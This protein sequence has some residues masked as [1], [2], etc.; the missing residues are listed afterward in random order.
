M[1][2]LVIAAV[3]WHPGE[4]AGFWGA[5][6]GRILDARF[7]MR[8]PLPPPDDVAVLLID[9]T[10]IAQIGH[11]P[12]PRSVLAAAIDKLR[13]S[14]ASAV[15]VDLLLADPSPDDDALRVTLG[16][17]GPVVLATA[18][19][20]PPST[21]DVLA[22]AITRSG[23]EVA[24]SA[25]PNAL[26]Q[27]LGPLP[28]FAATSMIGHANLALGSEGEL[29]SLPAALPFVG[30]DGGVWVPG[31][32]LAALRAADPERFSPLVLR[33][34][35]AGNTISLGE[36][37][38][39]LDRFGAIPLVFYGGGGTVPTWT[40]RDLDQA[41]VEGRIVFLGIAAQGAQ[42]SRPTPFDE[43]MPGVEAHAT[44]A[45]NVIEGRSLRRDDAA[46]AWGG[47]L[48]VIVAA[49][50]Y[51]V[52]GVRARVAAPCLAGIALAAGATLQAAFLA[53]WW[54]DATTVLVCFALAAGVGIA[55]RALRQSRRARNLSRYHA[56]SLLD[57]LAD[58][59]LSMLDG[60]QMN[61]AALF[62]DLSGFTGRSEDVGPQ[63]TGDMLNQFHERVAQ[64]ASVHG[65]V[66]D[67]IIG[68]AAM[69]TFGLPEPGPRDAASAL[70]FAAELGKANEV[71]ADPSQYLRLG[72]HFGPVEVRAL[73]GARHRHV[74]MVGDAV[75]AA[76][77]L[78]EAA[79]GAGARLAVSD[80]LLQQSGTPGRWID[81]L[82]LRDLGL[83]DLRGRKM[84]LHVWV[85]TP[86]NQA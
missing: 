72:A 9:D 76:S 13:T 30:A 7:L 67:Q 73:G 41:N 86:G 56:P 71:E 75:N 64:L 5:L 3:F 38:M 19:G 63:G 31:L 28:V 84:Q 6:E 50:A 42:D 49:F 14:G 1:A 2:V 59:D 61:A 10:D 18:R 70:A 57:A 45:G 17:P 62:V 43:A 20:G 16:Q 55:R 54:L 69:V 4:R 51:P 65:G 83:V 85:D 15:A 21:P 79:K 24:V 25:A 39:P 35:R 46:W 12:P 77:R 8:G 11:F 52:T 53:G 36:T 81:T 60:R 47:L 58:S 33:G 34:P 66:V 27:P 78:Q 29:R 40:L 23:V 48:A 26:D 68:D 74:T 37:S 80:T 82:G 44:L 32:A 22:E